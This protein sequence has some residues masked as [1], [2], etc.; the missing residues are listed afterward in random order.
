MNKLGCTNNSKNF[1]LL[2]F[3]RDVGKTVR[4]EESMKKH[5]FIPAYPIHC[6]R[7]GTD[8]FKIKAGH[9]RFYVARKLGIPFYYVVCDDNASI[10]ELEDTTEKWTVKDYL[11]AHSRL[12]KNHDYLKLDEYVE[13]TG[14]GIKSAMSMLAGQSAGSGNFGHEFKNGTYKIREDSDH[15]WVV[16]DIVLHAKK[17]GVAFYNKNLFVQAISKIVWVDNFSISRL[18]SKMHLFAGFIEKKANLQQYLE[19]MEEIYNRQSRDKVPLAFLAAQKAK[20]RKEAQLIGNR[21]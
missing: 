13:Q 4:L 15:A 7:N 2:S 18:K 21:K 10:F 9:H 12:G 14:I 16:K 17:C 11:A 1:E 3:N 6:V 20:E 19:M 8:K 5:G